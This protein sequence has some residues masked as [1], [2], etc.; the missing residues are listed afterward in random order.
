VEREKGVRGSAR[1]KKERLG[2]FAVG[3]QE[4]RRR[5]RRRRTV[6]RKEQEGYII[7]LS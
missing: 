1:V 5:R 6:G 3:K 2:V 7:Q 4:R